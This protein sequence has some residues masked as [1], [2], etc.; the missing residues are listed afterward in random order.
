MLLG[1]VVHWSGDISHCSVVSRFF[2]IK[3][4]IERG[5]RRRERTEKSAELL[6]SRKTVRKERISV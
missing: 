5:V 6:K 3:T 1:T 4:K 2:V